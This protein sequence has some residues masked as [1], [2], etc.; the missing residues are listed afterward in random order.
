[1]PASEFERGERGGGGLPQ[2][3][4]TEQRQQRPLAPGARHPGQRRLCRSRQFKLFKEQPPHAFDGVSRSAS[5]HE[6]NRRRVGADGLWKP[7]RNGGWAELDGP[8]PRRLGG[9]LV[10]AGDAPELF[11]GELHFVPPNSS[12]AVSPS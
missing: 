7:R 2:S 5:A 11:F 3:G 1:M 8:R 4:R 10:L 9:W 6:L 12:R